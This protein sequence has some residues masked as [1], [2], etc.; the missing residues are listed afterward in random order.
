[1]LGSIVEKPKVARSDHDDARFGDLATTFAKDGYL[2]IPEFADDVE[3]AFIRTRLEAMWASKT[4]FDQGYQFDLVGDDDENKSLAFPQIIHPSMFA[5]ELLK[6]KFFAQAQ[7]LAKAL[8][9]PKARFSSDHALLKKPLIGPETPWHQ[10]Q[11]FRDPAFDYHEVSIW[12]ALQPTD[13][14][15]GCMRFMAGSHQWGTLPHQPLNGNEKVHA[16]ECIGEFD[17]EGAIACPLPVGGCTVHG[18]MTLHSAGPNRST[19]PR[20]AWVLIFELPPVPSATVRSGTGV[21][22]MTARAQREKH[23]KRHG[24]ALVVLRRHLSRIDLRDPRQ[25]MVL[26]RVIVSGGFRMITSRAGKS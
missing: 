19:R 8:L 25:I 17:R 5:P 16:M 14:Q 3:V 21:S 23:W 15:N 13:M 22:R 10:D 6:T 4:G 9:G 7:E 24:G 20:A 11:G 2:R 18:G 1:M 12:L 26:M